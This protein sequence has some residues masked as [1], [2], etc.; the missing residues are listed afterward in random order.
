MI[1]K[2]NSAS[3][4]SSKEYN[5]VKE[6]LAIANKIKAGKIVQAT[7]SFSACEKL[8][9]HEESPPSPLPIPR[10]ITTIIVYKTTVPITTRT[11][12]KKL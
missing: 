1:F 7:S 8:T 9:S 10:Y 12:I 11:I 5:N 4:D 3:I 6:G 2:E